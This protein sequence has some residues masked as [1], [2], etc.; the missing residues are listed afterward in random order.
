MP[1]CFL[2]DI[3]SRFVRTNGSGTC[4]VHTCLVVITGRE[5]RYNLRFDGVDF[6]RHVGF[7]ICERWRRSCT[8]D[9]TDQADRS[10]AASGGSGKARNRR[11]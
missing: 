8:E 10:W 3:E 2:D 7:N 6:V 11:L 4:T 9:V 1:C 5:F